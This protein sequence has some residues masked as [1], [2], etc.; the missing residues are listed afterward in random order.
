ME[1]WREGDRVPKSK[2]NGGDETR[3]G[4]GLVGPSVS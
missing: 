4:G 3:K 2:L 1:T